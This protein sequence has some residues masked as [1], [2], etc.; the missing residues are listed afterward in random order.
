VSRGHASPGKARVSAE[1]GRGISSAWYYTVWVTGFDS[2]VCLRF[3][4]PHILVH[5]HDDQ[6]LDE[7]LLR[8]VTESIDPIAHVALPS[9]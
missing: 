7:G 8:S 2:A 3:S 1:Q 6:D 5:W 9:G 4:V